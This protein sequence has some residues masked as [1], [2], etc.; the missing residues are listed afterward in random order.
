MW[1]IRGVL[2]T[3]GPNAQEAWQRHLDLLV[4]GMRPTNA[5]LAHRALSQHQVDR[6]LSKSD[7]SVA[8]AAAGGGATAGQ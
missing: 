4:A 2:E 5:A 6:I 3:T 1:S 7:G 8:R